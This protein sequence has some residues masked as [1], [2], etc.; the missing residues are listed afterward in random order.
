M[1]IANVS[2]LKVEVAAGSA[3]GV[4]GPGDELGVDVE[5]VIATAFVQEAGQGVGHAPQAAADLRAGE[6]DVL[7]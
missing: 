6:S 3:D 4:I 5:A 1:T 2:M 7:S